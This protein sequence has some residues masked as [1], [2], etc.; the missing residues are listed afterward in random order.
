METSG[1]STDHDLLGVVFALLCA[2]IVPLNCNKDDMTLA[3]PIR[4]Y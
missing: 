4:V 2:I 3:Q 1:R